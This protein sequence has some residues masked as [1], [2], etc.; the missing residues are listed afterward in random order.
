MKS[1]RR[2]HSKRVSG[3]GPRERPAR[4]CESQKEA[5]SVGGGTSFFSVLPAERG[6]NW[7]LNDCRAAYRTTQIVNST[8]VSD[9]GAPR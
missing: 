2:C 9:S 5:A 7:A 3:V 4:P 8:L 1:F 6:G